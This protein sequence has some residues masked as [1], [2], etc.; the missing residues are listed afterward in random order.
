M[1]AYG[2]AR[3]RC[4]CPVTWTTCNPTHLKPASLAGVGTTAGCT[5]RTQVMH[6][7]KYHNYQLAPAD[8]VLQRLRLR[9]QL[10]VWVRVQQ[11]QQ[12]LLLRVLQQG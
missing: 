5:T 6:N 8:C 7:H 2:K 1:K 11:Q 9:L 4:V 12:L 3:D 10:R